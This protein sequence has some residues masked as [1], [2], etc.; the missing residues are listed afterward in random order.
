[1]LVGWRLG[2][3]LKK[4]ITLG[5]ISTL[6]FFIVFFLVGKYESQVIWN[7]ICTWMW[8]LKSG[9]TLCMKF[10]GTL[11]YK[12][13]TGCKTPVWFLSTIWGTGTRDRQNCRESYFLD[14]KRTS[15]Y[16]SLSII[17]SRTAAFL[18]NFQ[19]PFFHDPTL[20]TCKGS[21]VLLCPHSIS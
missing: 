2:V 13:L 21:K 20:C 14:D 15:F 3:N 5:I 16:S 9:S 19:R 6:T 12:S 18:P 4:K 7:Y 8:M 10:I 11:K 17:N 1:M